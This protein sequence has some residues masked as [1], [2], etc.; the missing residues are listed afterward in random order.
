MNGTLL[1]RLVQKELVLEA[2]APPV[3][4]FMLKMMAAIGMV[5]YVKLMLNHVK[6]FIVLILR[7][8]TI[9]PI[10]VKLMLQMTKNALIKFVL[11]MILLL[12]QV[13]LPMVESIV[14]GTLP[15]LLLHVKKKPIV[16]LLDQLNVQQAH[17]HQNVKLMV[18]HV[19]LSLLLLL[20]AQVEVL[21][22]T[23][24]I[25]LEKFV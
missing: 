8:L 21:V 25:Q 10:T 12:V 20:H 24:I 23:E 9:A 17:S 16:L 22:K 7:R 11:I 15:L 1:K 5:Q 6:E 4:V 14:S 2:Q 19:K 13:L 18:Q 3:I